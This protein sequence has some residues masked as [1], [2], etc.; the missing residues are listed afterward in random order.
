MATWN[1]S[2]T[3]V[4]CSTASYTVLGFLPN[5]VTLHVPNF[6]H[7]ASINSPVKTSVYPDR[8]MQLMLDN[9]LTYRPALIKQYFSAYVSVNHPHRGLPP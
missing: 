4:G 6:G 7:V 9:I 3:S 2:V 5:T 8:A 1:Y